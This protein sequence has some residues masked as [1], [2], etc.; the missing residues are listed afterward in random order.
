MSLE[1][2]LIA[3][4]EAIGADIKALSQP[5]FIAT[6]QTDYDSL[7]PPDAGALYV[8]VPSA[9]TG[10]GR[11]WIALTQSGWDAIAPGEPNVAYIVVP[12]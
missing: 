9:A 1:A 10:Q 6:T 4:T 3:L 12:G 11:A 7:S 8:T 2:Q 5:A